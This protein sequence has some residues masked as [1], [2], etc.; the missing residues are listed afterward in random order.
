MKNKR[1]L[2]YCVIILLSVVIYFA[3]QALQKNGPHQPDFSGE[4]KSR[5]SISMG[6]NIVCCYNPG[7]RMLAKTMKIAAQANSLTIA[8]SSSPRLICP[9]VVAWLEEIEINSSR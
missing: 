6:G 5:E 2:L 8:V 9:I 4:W 1:N 7:D 3:V